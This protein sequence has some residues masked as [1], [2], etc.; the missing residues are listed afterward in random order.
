MKKLFILPML[1]VFLF[2]THS[3]ISFAWDHSIELGYG[4]SHDPNHSQYDNSGYL[5]TGDLFPLYQA[6][7]TFWSV[8][9]ALGKWRTTAPVNKNLQTAAL[10]LALRLYPFTINENYPPYLLGS[11]GPAYLS[12]RNFGENEQAKN[13]TFQFNFG[14]GVEF[15]QLDVNLRMVHF[16]NAYLAR[17]DEGFTILY[18]LS[19]GY[20]F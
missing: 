15:N 11:V 1:I 8:T 2:F 14:L 3:T 17:P 7:Y 6:P 12:S 16:S 18:L 20:L 10:S 5:L 9:G 4:I 13:V 19:L